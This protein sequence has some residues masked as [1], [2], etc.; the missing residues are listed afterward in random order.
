MDIIFITIIAIPFLIGIAAFMYAVSISETNVSDIKK[1]RR[2][3]E[4]EILRDG[5]RCRQK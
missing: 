4:Y 3:K 1:I 2:I 5:I